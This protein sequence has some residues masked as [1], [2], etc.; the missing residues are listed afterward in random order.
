VWVEA[1]LTVNFLK[2]GKMLAIEV[3]TPG[4][5]SHLIFTTILNTVLTVL[6]LW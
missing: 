4:A 6:I 5:S 1:C 2:L 3:N